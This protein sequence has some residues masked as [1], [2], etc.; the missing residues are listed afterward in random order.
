MR[1]TEVPGRA[2]RSSSRMHVPRIG[3]LLS[4][5]LLASN[6]PWNSSY[7]FA[8]NKVI[9][10]IELEGLETAINR[11]DVSYNQAPQGQE[12]TDW[13]RI[14]G[15]TYLF[16]KNSQGQ[17]P[18]N[19]FYFNSGRRGEANTYYRQITMNNVATNSSTNTTTST[20]APTTTTATV[21]GGGLGFTHGRQLPLLR[22][23]QRQRSQM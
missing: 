15:N 19:F 2:T 22:Q 3:R 4:L 8:E 12:G 13:A 21:D 14:E 1:Y 18:G 11:M 23:Q 5:D 6:F 10:F 7:A 9:Q 16:Q 20:G 17:M